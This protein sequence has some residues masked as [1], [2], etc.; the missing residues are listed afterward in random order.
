M[1]G[2]DY[3]IEQLRARFEAKLFTDVS[4]HTYSSLG[5]AFWTKKTDEDGRILDIPRLQTSDTVKYVEVLP[6]H[7]I[8]GHSFFISDTG[9][10]I[11]IDLKSKVSIYFS[12]NLDKLYPNIS[13]RAVEYLHRDVIKALNTI[14]FKLLHIETDLPAFNRFGFIEEINNLEPYYLVRF[15]TEVEYTLKCS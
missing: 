12:V 4:G 1:I 13:E 15:D 6:N 8:D 7:R 3:K 11:G 9:I 14:Q 2:L 10:D 5:R